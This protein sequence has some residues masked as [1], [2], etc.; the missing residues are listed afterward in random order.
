[1]NLR[2][3]REPSSNGATLGS[4]YLDDVWFCWTLE[5]QI[6]EVVGQAVVSWKVKGQTAIPAGRY[7]VRWHD[8]PRFGR[9]LPILED[10]PGFSYIL[11]HA[12][13]KSADTD[14]CILV[15]LDRGHAF[16]GRSQMA[17]QRVIERLVNATG[18]IWITIENPPRYAAVAA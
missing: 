15:G 3:I 4:L 7:R 1:M 16:V 2:I 5:D 8:S 12:G 17:L 13:N 18:D 9:R 14:G 11:I 6:R 10:V